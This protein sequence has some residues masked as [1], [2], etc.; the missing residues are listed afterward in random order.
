MDNR[1]VSFTGTPYQSVGL[2]GYMGDSQYGFE[3]IIEQLS[4]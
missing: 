4:R 2:R 1:K 3:Y